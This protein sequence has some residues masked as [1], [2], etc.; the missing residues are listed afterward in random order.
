MCFTTLAC[1]CVLVGTCLG[2]C[3]REL[4]YDNGE[5]QEVLDGRLSHLVVLAFR[6]LVP[7]PPL[8][9]QHMRHDEEV[10]LVRVNSVTF[11]HM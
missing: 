2:L 3:L 5:A 8:I 10:V 9:F 4:K 11:L 7:E 1:L 6:I